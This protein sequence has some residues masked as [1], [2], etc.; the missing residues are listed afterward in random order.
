MEINIYSMKLYHLFNL[1]ISYLWWFLSKP[2]TIPSLFHIHEN[3][4]RMTHK[5]DFF[6][7]IPFLIN[8]FIILSPPTPY[9]WKLLHSDEHTQGQS[10]PH[11][12][13]LI[14]RCFSQFVSVFRYLWCHQT[15]RLWC[16]HQTARS[17]HQSIH[18]HIQRRFQANIIALCWY[19]S[20]DYLILIE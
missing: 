16:L 7:L 11:N 13:Q 8:I 14:R 3:I 9:S 1:F 4:T 20:P 12:S 17:S 5:T 15:W 10:V 19:S 2:A 18:L 6:I